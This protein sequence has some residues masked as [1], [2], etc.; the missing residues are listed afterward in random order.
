M[1]CIAPFYS[2]EEPNDGQVRSLKEGKERILKPGNN[3]V[4]HLYVNMYKDSK[5][6]KR[7]IHRLMADAFIP[8]PE[9]K[10]MVRHLNDNP[11]DNRL[12]NL[13]WGTSKENVNDA[14]NNGTSNILKTR[15]PVVL[16]KDGI[17]KV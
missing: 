2:K 4:G 7:Y 5:L 14:I 16:I 13:A 11:K 8:N 15:V 9:E 17:S 10:P 3:G 6:S 12:E 1:Q